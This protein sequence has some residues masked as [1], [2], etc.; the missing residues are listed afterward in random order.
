MFCL[1]NNRK[2]RPRIEL[3]LLFE[4]D[5]QLLRFTIVVVVELAAGLDEDVACV[6]SGLIKLNNAKK[7]NRKKSNQLNVCLQSICNGEF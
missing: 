3:E 1:L 5:N 4:G 6:F 2:V 7:R